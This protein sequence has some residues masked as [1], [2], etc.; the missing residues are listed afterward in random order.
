MTSQPIVTPA[1][2]VAPATDH[3]APSPSSGRHPGR[4]TLSLTRLYLL[5]AG[6]LLIGIGL[7]LVKWPELVNHPQP[8][9]LFESVVACMLVALSLLAFLGVRYPVQLLP[10]MLF[11]VAWKL[12]WMGLVAVPLW[13]AGR[14]DEATTSVFF[15]CALVVV[16]VAVIP[17]RYVVRE[18][19]TT[20][21]DRWR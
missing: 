1:D 20:P 16:I 4:D 6:Y 10:V 15:S 11:E 8:W 7:V 5:R 3:A 17:W 13:A 12:L 18:Y 2:P 14:L 19:L 9:P 21:G